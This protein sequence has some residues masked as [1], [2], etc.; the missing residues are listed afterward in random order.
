[1]ARLRR[2]V[3]E[4]VASQERHDGAKF[5]GGSSH[6][7]LSGEAAGEDFLDPEPPRDRRR[8][9]S[10]NKLEQRGVRVNGKCVSAGCRLAHA[11]DRLTGDPSLR[12]KNGCGSG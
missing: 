5:C 1:M 4:R 10:T 2:N 12:L 6:N 11:F 9:M 8:P 3:G 7:E